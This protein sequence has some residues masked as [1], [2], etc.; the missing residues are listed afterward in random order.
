MSRYEVRTSI[1]ATE[2]DTA[3]FREKEISKRPRKR[4]ITVENVYVM[5]ID[6]Y[7]DINLPVEVGVLKIKLYRIII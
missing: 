5:Q 6:I 1:R 3:S 7:S 2:H 4:F